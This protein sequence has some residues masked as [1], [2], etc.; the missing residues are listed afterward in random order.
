M[1][2]TVL[3]IDDDVPFLSVMQRR[4]ELKGGYQVQTFTSG[5]AALNATSEQTVHAIILDMMLGNESGLDA[6]TQL[7]HR[8]APTHFIMLTG[9]ASIATTVEAM[10]RG[11]TD[12]ISKPVTLNELLARLKGIE[13]ETQE[14]VKPMT[15]GQI[16]WEYIQRALHDNQ[17]NVSKT[18]R[19]LGMH[20][21][22][23]Q[24]KLSK[25]SP[26]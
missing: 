8:F 14:A 17:G 9:Y 22:T 19:E 7:K 5:K 21:R 6:I 26:H 15:P 12:Y 1:T 23:L 18:A 16:E 4:L 24:R 11:A 25:R 13:S 20:R 10:K 3:L 2:D